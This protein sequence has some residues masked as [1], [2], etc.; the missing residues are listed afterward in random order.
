M[1]NFAFPNLN[2]RNF[3]LY[4]HG[5]PCIS[6]VTKIRS[7]VLDLRVDR[8]TVLEEIINAFLQIFFGSAL[9]KL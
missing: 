2:K 6:N 5:T 7:S 1:L 3:P 9:R 8:K 4:F